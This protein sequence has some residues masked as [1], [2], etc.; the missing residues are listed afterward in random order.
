MTTKTADQIQFQCAKESADV[1]HE[2][3]KATNKDSTIA[4]CCGTITAAIGMLE[5]LCTERE[6]YFYLQAKADA[7]IKPRLLS[8]R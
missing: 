8:D 6:V 4:A 5:H 2:W 1:F 7:A 3:L